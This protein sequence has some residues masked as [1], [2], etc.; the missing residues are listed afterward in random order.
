MGAS[1]VGPVRV[2]HVTWAITP[3]AAVASALM[4][5]RGAAA[6]GLLGPVDTALNE[7]QAKERIVEFQDRGGDTSRDQRPR[8][9]CV[10]GVRAVSRLFTQYPEGDLV[11][12]FGRELA[13]QVPK[14]NPSS[15]AFSQRSGRHAMPLTRRQ[16]LGATGFGQEGWMNRWKPA[17]NAF[18]I[19]F[20]G[21]LF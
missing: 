15:R 7:T 12:K 2:G 8:G 5:T 13:C 21:R 11:N 19:T 16:V 4:G 10:H 9:E 6:D 17:L 20:E 18:A 3:P 14:S 1:R